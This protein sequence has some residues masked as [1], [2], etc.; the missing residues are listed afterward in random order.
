MMM[1]NTAVTHWT[2]V[3]L[4]GWYFNDAPFLN[5][6]VWSLVIVV[7]SHFCGIFVS[8]TFYFIVYGLKMKNRP[9][10]N[11]QIILP[12]LASGALWHVLLVCCFS[13]NFFILMSPRAIRSAAQISWFVANQ[14]LSFVVSFPIITTGLID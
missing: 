9:Q 10:V 13:C 7:F 6:C 14:E 2:T 4:F 11:P 5:V 8:S 12:A 3:C 1:V